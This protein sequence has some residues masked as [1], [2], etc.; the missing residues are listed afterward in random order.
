MKK[1]RMNISHFRKIFGEI[2]T[3]F[4]KTNLFCS[5]QVRRKTRVKKKH[6]KKTFFLYLYVAP[7]GLFFRT[8]SD[9][10]APCQKK[11]KQFR[12]LCPK[13]SADW[14]FAPARAEPLFLFGRFDR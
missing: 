12:T 4:K 13:K 10:F 9:F 1:A 3:I 5:Y 14:D 8:L 6:Q 2:V 11:F 7:C